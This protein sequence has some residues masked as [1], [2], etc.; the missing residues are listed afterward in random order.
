MKC[1][2]PIPAET[3]TELKQQQETGLGYQ[4]VSVH[5]KDGRSFDQVVVSEGCI[6]IVRGYTEVPF[7]P[8]EVAAVKVNNKRWNFGIGLIGANTARRARLQSL[9]M[10]VTFPLLIHSTASRVG[11]DRFCFCRGPFSKEI[12]DSLERAAL[13]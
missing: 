6:I 12:R 3:A 11:R 13:F 2:V 1:L 5:L 8:D 7:R 4:V 9:R 10:F